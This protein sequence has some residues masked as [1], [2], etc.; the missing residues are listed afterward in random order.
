M[1]NLSVLLTSVV[2]V[3][4]G[5]CIP[6]MSLHP[7]YHESD[8]VFEEALVG[9]WNDD[10]NDPN[11]AWSFSRLRDTNDLLLR[12]DLKEKADKLYLLSLKNDGERK[13]LFLAGLI[14][15]DD[16]YYLDLFPAKYPSGVTD[17]DTLPL[18]F[19]ALFMTPL[20]T[21]M[22]VQFEENQL[23]L[24]LTDD[25]SMEKLFKAHP[26]AVDYLE[27]HDDQLLLT[28]STCAL[29]TFVKRYAEDERLFE[30]ATSLQRL[31]VDSHP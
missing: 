6:V 31:P 20:H 19:N 21:F 4:I 30:E 14:K 10:P 18:P 22:R 15:L 1:K 7:L 8:L 13:G 5:G 3:L 9:A 11:E 23:K 26:D 25:D 12:D 28:A 24:S 2:T 16:R 27:V 29:Q 17:I